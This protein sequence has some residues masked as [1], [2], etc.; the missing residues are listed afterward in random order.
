M[1]KDINKYVVSGISDP[2][3]SEK[4][5]CAFYKN[6]DKKMTWGIHQIQKRKIMNLVKKVLENYKNVWRN[7]H[8]KC[9]DVF[10]SDTSRNRDLLSL[11][12]GKMTIQN[13]EQSRK[14]MCPILELGEAYDN[15][16]FELAN[17][18]A[19]S[20]PENFFNIRDQFFELITP[21]LVNNNISSSKN[22]L[23]RNTELVCRKI[24]D[25][26]W[27]P[28]NSAYKILVKNYSS[29]S[30]YRNPKNEKARDSH[31]GF[32]LVGVNPERYRDAQGNYTNMSNIPQKNK[33]LLPREY[34]PNV[35]DQAWYIMKNDYSEYIMS[36]QGHMTLYS[37]E[38]QEIG[39]VSITSIINEQQKVK[40]S[41]EISS[42]FKKIFG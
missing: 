28:S 12:T 39:G 20:F 26:Y 29:H 34:S 7:C 42:R 9:L 23:K 24:F 14:M 5:I 8:N 36:Y 19:Q 27:K 37:R 40:S 13:V 25:D 38:G 1:A 10:S 17:I 32:T 22:G 41:D 11:M 31:F 2:I 30:L 33:V 15:T 6:L 21:I 18:A 4:G 35:L 3:R 16:I